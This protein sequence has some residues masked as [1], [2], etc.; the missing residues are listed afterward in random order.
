MRRGLE[1]ARGRIEFLGQTIDA[2]DPFLRIRQVALLAG[3]EVHLV[4]EVKKRLAIPCRPSMLLAIAV[5]SH[6]A[7]L[8]EEPKN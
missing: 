4:R 2:L 6:L 7:A 3:G 5:T 1:P 8:F